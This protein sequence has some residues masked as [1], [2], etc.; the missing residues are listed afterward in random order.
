MRACSYHPHLP[1]IHVILRE[2]SSRDKGLSE[3]TPKK[4]RPHCRFWATA[5][6][7]TKKKTRPHCRSGP[8]KDR[9][10]RKHHVCL[11]TGDAYE[12]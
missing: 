4:T 8:K 10:Q 7:R 5:S 11:A 6:E 9:P 2:R 12:E 3:R 1:A